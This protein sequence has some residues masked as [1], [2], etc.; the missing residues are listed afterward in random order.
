MPHAA[1]ES[2][3]GPPG[4]Q[5]TRRTRR[6]RAR[7][8]LRTGPGGLGRRTS[9]RETAETAETAVVSSQLARAQAG[10]GGLRLAQAGSRWPI[11]ARCWL[12]LVSSR[13]LPAHWPPCFACAQGPEA[14]RWYEHR[15]ATSAPAE[16][17]QHPPSTHPATHPPPRS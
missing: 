17:T 11:A 15:R 10:S 14:C 13:L 3:R 12:W 6:T 1:E 8:R 4:L 5:G 2:Q 16:P 7:Q 9:V